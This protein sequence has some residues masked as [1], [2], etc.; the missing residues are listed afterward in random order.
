MPF[1]RPLQPVR[2]LAQR[3][4]L[5]RETRLRRLHDRAT[6]RPRKIHWSEVL[7]GKQIVF[8]RFIYDADVTKALG[9]RVWQGHVDLSPLEG[10]LIPRV[11]ET[12]YESFRS[13][14]DVIFTKIA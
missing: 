4:V 10:K 7:L 13:S 2:P 3:Y 11:V 8:T 5:G 14:H 1:D 9:F 6:K 12:D